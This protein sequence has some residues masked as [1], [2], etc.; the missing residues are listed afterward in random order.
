MILPLTGWII[1]GMSRDMATS[2]LRL[3]IRL[4]SNW[5]VRFT[6]GS[7]CAG[8]WTSG[9]REAP[10]A[11]AAGVQ[12]APR[13]EVAGVWGRVGSQRYGDLIFAPIMTVAAQL[14]PGGLDRVRKGSWKRAMGISVAA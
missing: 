10:L 3:R 13:H 8:F 4:V 6:D 11:P 5:R 14:A 9:S 7:Y 1:L 2:Q 12:K